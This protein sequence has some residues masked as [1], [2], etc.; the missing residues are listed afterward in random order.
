MEDG[1]RSTANQETTAPHT[2]YLIVFLYKGVMERRGVGLHE[3][4]HTVVHQGQED[5]DPELCMFY[6]FTAK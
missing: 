2:L 5:L 4:T 1:V 6:S 3:L